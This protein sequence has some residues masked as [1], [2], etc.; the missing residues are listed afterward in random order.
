MAGQGELDDLRIMYDDVDVASDMPANMYWKDF[1]KVFTDLKVRAIAPVSVFMRLR[2][3]S[4]ISQVIRKPAFEI[5]VEHNS[6][7]LKG[8]H[9]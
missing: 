5:I 7:M 6:E 1:L 8:Y 3:A 9:E 2:F 4:K